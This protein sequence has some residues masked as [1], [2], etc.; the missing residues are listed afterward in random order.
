MLK[1]ISNKFSADVIFTV[2]LPG[3]GI[4]SIEALG[5][6]VHL[7]VLGLSKNSIENLGPLKK[8]KELRIVDLS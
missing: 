1:T 3:Q 6:C 2:V 7:A 4:G 5:E 8:L